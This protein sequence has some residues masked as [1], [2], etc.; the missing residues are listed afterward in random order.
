MTSVRRTQ[1]I[2][3]SYAHVDNL[4]LVEG[5]RGWVDFLHRALDL[6]LAQLTGGTVGIWRDPKLAGND[7]SSEQMAE[8]ISDTGLFVPIVTPRYV[9]SE[10]CLRE[11]GYFI[12]SHPDTALSGRVFKVLPMPV[13]RNGQPPELAQLLG[14]EFFEDDPNT[15]HTRQ[16]TP[17]AEGETAQRFWAT[18]EDLSYDV[19]KS[20]NSWRA[21]RVSRAAVSEEAPATPV[22]P[23]PTRAVPPLIDS[24]ALK[25]GPP[26]EMFV[27]YSRD[28]H[29]FAIQLAQK[30]ES[31]GVHVFVDQL[32]IPAGA[33]W[34][35]SIDAAL[36]R[37]AML[38]VVLSPSAV[39]SDQVR[40]EW[41]MALEERKPVLPVLHK[42]CTVPRQLRLY[43]HLDM[44]EGGLLEDQLLT[45]LAEAIKSV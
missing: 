36:E 33:D 14:Y 45:R 11:L 31:R 41:N 12:D 2:F 8:Q 44:T 21:S 25:E 38:V 4:S 37:C 29:D 34:D 16:L 35:R 1:D 26:K 39:E 9:C 40:S 18:L 28:D 15:D 23:R 30:L 13:E 27:C 6:R 10:R 20:L 5:S 19:S 3:I 32:S 42:H 7:L 22:G 24:S 17:E 43:Q